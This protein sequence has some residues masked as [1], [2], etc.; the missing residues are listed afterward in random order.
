MA[1]RNQYKFSARYAIVTGSGAGIGLA[2]AHRLVER[3]ATVSL[4]ER[5]PALLKLARSTFSDVKPLLV[6]VDVADGGAVAVARDQTLAAAAGIDIL[7]TSVGITG[8]NNTL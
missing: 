6:T 8:P 3:G 2:I 7:V 1:E 5:D 4:W